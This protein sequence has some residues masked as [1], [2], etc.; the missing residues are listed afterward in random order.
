[1]PKFAANLTLLFNELP[2]VERFAA[3]RRA[4]FAA[5]EVLF[6]YDM[7][8]PAILDRL[9]GNDL[10]LVLMNGPPP[11]YTDRPRG[12]AAIPGGEALF[13]QDFVR[14][15]RVARLLRPQ[16]L[17]LMAGVAQ[18]PAARAAMIANLTWAATEAPDLS[19]TIEPINRA[20]MPGYFLNDFA[21][22]AE[23]LDA[24]GMPNVRL[25]FDAYHAHRI[26]GDVMATWAQV[27]TRV[28]HVQVG[29]LPDRREPMAGVVDYP[30][31]FAALD[32][33]GYRGWVAGEYHPAGRTDEGLEWARV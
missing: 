4:G 3:A 22:A 2:F 17:H 12:F 30:A 31:F 25:Q 27:R 8:A 24:V 6:P 11:N 28:A 26:T 1:M 19:L 9:S 21:M 18:G 20:D 15:L 13:R 29:G 14:A 23:I 33:D 7:P 16:H 5:V 32:A 10:T